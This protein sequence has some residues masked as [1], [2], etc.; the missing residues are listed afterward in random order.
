MVL[1][2]LRR[3]LVPR[4]LIRRLGSKVWKEFEAEPEVEAAEVILSSSGLH[5]QNTYTVNTLEMKESSAEILDAEA[6]QFQ[7]D[8]EQLRAEVALDVSHARL[9]R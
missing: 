5:R 9:L 3:L 4:A 6:H 8:L 2:I 1:T 7:L